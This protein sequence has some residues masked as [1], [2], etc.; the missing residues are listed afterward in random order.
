MIGDKEFELELE[1]IT[2]EEVSFLAQD[3][4][5]TVLFSTDWQKMSNG[6]NYIKLKTDEFAIARVYIDGGRKELIKRLQF[7]ES[8]LF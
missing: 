3:E 6:E 2:A 8:R 4:N 7:V 5:G 1:G